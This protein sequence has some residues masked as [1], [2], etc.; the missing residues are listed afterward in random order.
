M[1]K[2]KDTLRKMTGKGPEHGHHEHESGYAYTGNETYGAAGT[3]AYGA[4]GQEQV[5]GMGVAEVPVVVTEQERVHEHHHED[6]HEEV[7]GTKTFTEVEDRP[8][9][10]ERVERILEHQPVEKQYV[11]E[12]KFVGEAA[13]PSS[14]GARIIDTNER[15]VERAEPGPACPTGVGAAMDRVIDE[16]RRY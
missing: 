5:V 8:I 7:C 14:E 13:I 1:G 3:E 4:T 15:V 2:V 16:T 12:T 6:R 11:V 9:I 10:K